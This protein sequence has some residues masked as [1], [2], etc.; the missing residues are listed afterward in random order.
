MPEVPGVAKGAASV[1]LELGHAPPRVVIVSGEDGLGAVGKFSNRSQVIP[2]VIERCAIA[3]HEALLE[4]LLEHH[5][6]IR[7]PRLHDLC[8]V[9]KILGIACYL[10]SLRTPTQNWGHGLVQA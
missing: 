5:S 9:P 6:T 10:E 8:A 7:G 2:G 4:V 1:A 3:I